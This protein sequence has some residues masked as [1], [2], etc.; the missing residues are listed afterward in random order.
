[1]KN[2]DD[3]C[4]FDDRSIRDRYIVTAVILLGD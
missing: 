1:M 2:I 3:V 4:R